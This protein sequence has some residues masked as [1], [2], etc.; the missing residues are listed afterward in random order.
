MSVVSTLRRSHVALIVKQYF[1]RVRPDLLEA[2][3][4]VAADLQ[5]LHSV[6]VRT[7]AGCED[8][9]TDVALGHS[10]GHVPQTQTTNG[11]SAGRT[12]CL[13]GPA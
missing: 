13:R 6:R 3:G 11:I 9:Q 7:D 4:L 1:Q 10:E 5:A 12:R 8:Q 2:D